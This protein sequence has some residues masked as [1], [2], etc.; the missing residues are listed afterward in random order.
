[1][2]RREWKTPYGQ[3]AFGRSD[4]QVKNT[5]CDKYRH[6]ELHNYKCGERDARHERER[7]HGYF[8]LTNILK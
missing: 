6:H 7:H 8:A 3:R 5:P 4:N 1:M 2:E